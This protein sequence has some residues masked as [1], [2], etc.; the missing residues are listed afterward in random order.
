MIWV[1]V[2]LLGN[3][4]NI[5]YFRTPAICLYFWTWFTFPARRIALTDNPALWAKCTKKVP[6]MLHKIALDDLALPR[7]HA[8]VAHEDGVLRSGVSRPILLVI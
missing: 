8:G 3:A 6:Q 7:K 5:R 4:A 1:E 2:L